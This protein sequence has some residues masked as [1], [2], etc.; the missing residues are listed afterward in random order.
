MYQA[1]GGIDS[2]VAR[3]HAV[4][5]CWLVEFPEPVLGHCDGVG[6]G[7]RGGDGL[8][9]RASGGGERNW[10]VYRKCYGLKTQL[11]RAI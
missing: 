9:K 11:G 4:E 8:V 1:A 7:L 6:W 3:P 2:C 5:P 10:F